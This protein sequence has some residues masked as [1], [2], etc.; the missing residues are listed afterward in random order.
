MHL[1]NSFARACNEKNSHE[2]S[3]GASSVVESLSISN[4]L[5]SI[6]PAL[7]SALYNLVIGGSSSL[8]KSL[9]IKIV[10]WCFTTAVKS[11][12]RDG[13]IENLCRQSLAVSK[14]VL[15]QYSFPVCKRWLST[16]D[17]DVADGVFL[18]HSSLLSTAA[19][20]FSRT[21]L[22]LDLLNASQIESVS[23]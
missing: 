5:E 19:S 17:Q 2:E 7:S 20:A 11:S 16:S 1:L 6:C 23:L 14:A 22:Y 13:L 21:A 10:D 18:G 4:L 3:D 9:A 15:L 12:V 8:S